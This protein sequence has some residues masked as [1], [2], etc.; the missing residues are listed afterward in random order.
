V[1][2]HL[3]GKVLIDTNVFI[4]YL[5][6]GTHEQWVDGQV[7]TTVRYLSSVVLMELR[8]G[9]DTLPRRR[10]VDQFRAYFPDRRVVAPAPA[11]FDRAGAIFRA[12][13]SPGGEPTDRLGPLNDILIALT[14]RQIGATVISSNAQDFERIAEHLPGLAV[15][16]P[17]IPGG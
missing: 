17:L 8:L 2:L 15:L 7:G 4:D 3:D 9:A 1:A 12:L 10:M 11:S 14:A 13:F 16:N 6:T 5:R